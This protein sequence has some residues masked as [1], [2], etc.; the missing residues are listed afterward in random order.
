MLQKGD[1]KMTIRNVEIRFL[2][3]LDSLK[4]TENEYIKRLD[5][6]KY[7]KNALT[8]ES[9]GLRYFNGKIN[10]IRYVKDSIKGKVI[11]DGGCGSGAFSVILSL[12]GAKKVYAIDYL[13]DCIELTKFMIN[14]ANLDNV[15]V[16]H[17]DIIE[18]DL[19][20]KSIDGIF[21]IEAISH[22]RN[23][24]SFLEMASRVL[25]KG[26]FLVIRDGNNAASPHIR[27][28]TFK[29]WDVF[30]NYPKATTI[31]GHQKGDTCYLDMRKEIIKNEFSNLSQDEIEKFAKYTFA[32]SRDKIVKV[33]K[34]FIEGNFSLKSEYSYGKCP[35]DPETDCYMER[36]F[37]P[38]DLKH[39][40]RNYGFKSKIKSNG[41][42]RRDLRVLRYFWELLSPITIFLPRGFQIIAIKSF[43]LHNVA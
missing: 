11:I 40:L 3:I 18:L 35:L 4:K 19:P 14:I 39:E 1:I 16:I 10:D 6:Y 13:A 41:P 2:S 37:N 24:E 15:E 43:N 5:S 12:L 7:V 27:K 28:K 38:I 25:K 42:A 8:S 23:Y 32:Y 31:F 36:L 20:E 29:T 34:Q 26:G 9:T 30:E 33:I 17:N 21:S 22:Y